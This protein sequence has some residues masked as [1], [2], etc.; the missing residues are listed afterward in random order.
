MRPRLAVLILLV[1][2]S[3]PGCGGG[4]SPTAPSPP[5][6]TYPVTAVVFYDENGNGVLDATEAVRLSDID[7]A[8]SGKVGRSEKL[9][10]RAVVN[11]VP[12]GSF[13]VTLQT[14]SMP[15]FWTP[16]TTPPVA[17]P[18]P[19]G[20][21]ADIPVTLP[22]GDNVPNTYLAFGDS[23]TVGEGSH[24]TNGYISVVEELLAQYMGGRHRVIGDGISGTTSGCSSNRDCSGK[25][26]AER[27]EADLRRARPAY[28]L[29]LYGTN[30]WNKAPCKTAEPPCFTI[31]SLRFMIQVAK[32]QRTLPV[33]STII[34]ANPDQTPPERNQWVAAMNEK[35][36]AMARQEGAALAD[37]YAA[38]MKAG[39][40][41]A[42]FDGQVH[43]NDAGYQL[44]AGA[45]FIAMERPPAATG[46][47]WGLP[48]LFLA[49]AVTSVRR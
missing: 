19:A 16:S 38:F 2:T 20:S 24:S 27:I 10:G 8:V 12:A 43:P 14:A 39:S 28:L 31:D 34:P 7:V 41:P 44:I 1:A 42:L 45:F 6:P 46:S 23:I 30:D 3:L 33:V 37:S 25:E 22:I 4:G 26:G 49:P 47:R 36:K 21:E 17:V 13:P 5:A 9:T 40:L 32:G 35:I 11:G 48:S 15:P 18:Q 29:I